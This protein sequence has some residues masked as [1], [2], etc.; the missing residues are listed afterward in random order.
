MNVNKLMAEL[1]A[2]HPGEVE[3]LQAV[4]EVLESIEEVYNQNPQFESAK[5]IERMV[6]PDRIF[7]FKVPWTDDEGNV[8]VNLG[9]RVQ[10]NN[11]IGPYKGG[12]RF[13]PSVNLS[14]LKFL[15]F[16]QIFKNALT[17]LPMGGA[18][19]GSDFNP[20]GRSDAEIMRFCQSF[21]L[22]LWKHIG[23][24]TDVPAGDIGVGGREIGFLY[25]MYKK[26]ASENTGVLTGKGI[27]WGGSLIRPEATGFGAT[28]FAQEML[29]TKGMSFAGK[30]VALS[31]FGNVAWG[32]AIKVTEL[33]GKVVTISG[34]D[35]YVLDEDGISGEKI[36]YLLELRAS[37]Q[38][39]VE[40]YAKKFPNAKFFAG[41]RPWE[42]KVDV[43][44]PC[45][46]QN[47]LGK[48]DA[49]ALVKNGCV[50]VAEGA[51]MPCT[52]EAIEVLQ[53]NKILFAPGKA[54]NAGGVATSGLEMTQ[55]SMKL[56][57]SREEVDAR[58][59][60]IMKNIHEAC[61]KHGTEKDGYVNYVK[62]ANIAGFLKVA[63]AMLDQG[64]L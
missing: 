26:L 63:N 41:K 46:T 43:A 7:I 17:T 21:M 38:D 13:H 11:A 27:N 54:V 56:S 37:N 53:Q 12:L 36:D 19:G 33:G 6:E 15:G 8:H 32:A 62:G 22:E 14:I 16:E 18:K 44:M 10:F 60:Q 51:N 55:N 4:R 25:G 40:P 30:R 45:A 48:E 58:L 29:A 64:I 39:I 57:W 47:E 34:P 9:Y 61:V 24:E 28:Y 3:Y 35:G 52:P 1:E 20:K 23:P 31:G 2:K 42:V 5:I 49:E 50:C 59:Q